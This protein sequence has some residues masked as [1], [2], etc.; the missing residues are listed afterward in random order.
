MK[1][2]T[3][4]KETYSGSL[5]A[6]SNKNATMKKIKLTPEQQAAEAAR[7]DAAYKAE[8]ERKAAMKAQRREDN[9]KHVAALVETATRMTEWE[10][11]YPAAPKAVAR[12]ARAIGDAWLSAHEELMDRSGRLAV[13]PA[14]YFEWAESDMKLAAKREV[15][16]RM[17]WAVRKSEMASEDVVAQLPAYVSNTKETL[18]SD[19]LGNR[20]RP[21]STSA[22]HNAMMIYK[23]EAVSSLLRYDINY[24]ASSLN[25]SCQ[26]S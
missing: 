22:A 4:T 16:D 12:V 21:S 1:N 2:A 20:N 8:Q 19:L 15:L 9:A 6:A 25:P 11:V 17:V 14:D 24:W 26:V 10:T 18:T 7:R 13:N 3:E 23:N 5:A